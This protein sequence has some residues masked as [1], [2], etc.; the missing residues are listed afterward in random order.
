MDRRRAL[1]LTGC[2]SG[3]GAACAHGM[4][5]RGWR[6]CATARRRDDL[7]RLE[8]A[9]VEAL[10]CDYTDE[11][12]IA[13]TF[14]A[15]MAATAGRLDAL[16]N[17]G[18]YAQPGAL[19]DLP[20]A[21]LR[22]QFE[23]N[24]F[25]WHD[26]T[27]R[28]IPVMRRQRAGRIVMNSSVLGLIA[29][30]FRGAYNATKFAVEAYADTLRIE[31]DGSGIE[32]CTIEP[33][34]IESRIGQNAVPHFRRHIDIEGSVHRDF[35]RRRLASLERGGETRGQLGPE[36]VLAALVHA[37]ESPRPRTHYRVTRPAEVAAALR[38][39]LPRRALHR[40]MVRATR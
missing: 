40:L 25:G 20:T 12:T 2:S 18:A 13:A 14:G 5:A 1:L 32:V 17:N 35:Y 7:E 24:F 37:C 15:V 31:L 38:R 36:A 3:I 11:E 4:Q 34:P 8:R 23:A 9:G 39:V 28:A 22:E 6:V 21:A 29:L 26:L 16:F 33:G 30:G 19:E 27:R 10:R